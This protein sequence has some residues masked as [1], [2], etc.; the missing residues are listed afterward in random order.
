MLHLPRGHDVHSK[1]KEVAIG[2]ESDRAVP[3]DGESRN[4]RIHNM[5]GVP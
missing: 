3:F 5:C 2:S 1:R 4:G